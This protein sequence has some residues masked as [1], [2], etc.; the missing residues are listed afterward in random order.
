M[1]TCCLAVAEDANWGCARLVGA[2][3][4]SLFGAI[5]ARAGHTSCRSVR[6]VSKSMA[7]FDFAK[8]IPGWKPV[9]SERKMR[10]FPRR[11][12][13]GSLENVLF[14]G[15]TVMAASAFEPAG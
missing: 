14:V 4:N 6:L 11:E 5:C 7:E 15:H 1:G 10:G 13:K 8:P 9:E 3:K 12:I 2:S